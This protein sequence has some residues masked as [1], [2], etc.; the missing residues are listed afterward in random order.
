V[1]SK[2]GSFFLRNLIASGVLAFGADHDSVKSLLICVGGFLRQA[3]VS[4]KALSAPK[5][6]GAVAVDAR[7]IACMMVPFARR[8]VW[9]CL[10]IA[11]RPLAGSKFVTVGRRSCVVCC[12]TS[13]YLCWVLLQHGA[14]D[15][16]GV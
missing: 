3:L 15:S 11:Q 2:G 4:P 1:V 9:R 16:P 13:L 8:G 14:G 12:Y 7:G 5:A 6:L 10:M